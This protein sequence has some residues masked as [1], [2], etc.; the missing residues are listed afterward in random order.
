MNG[1]GDKSVTTQESAVCWKSKKSTRGK[2][3]ASVKFGSAVV[4]IYRLRSDGRTRFMLS[5][6]QEGKRERRSFSNL[7]AAKKEALLVAQRIQGR[8]QEMNDLRPHDGEAYRTL[9]ELL[10]PSGVP[11]VTAVQEYVRAN[12]PQRT[13]PRTAF[14]I[15]QIRTGRI[16][17]RPPRAEGRTPL[18]RRHRQ[19]PPRRRPARHRRLRIHRCAGTVRRPRQNPPPQGPRRP[20]PPPRRQGAPRQAKKHDIPP[21]DLVVVNL[22]PFEETVAKPDVTL[23]EAIENI[24]IGGPS[25][26]RSAAKNHSHVTVVVDPADYPRVIAEMKSTT[27]TPPRACASSSP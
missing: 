6:Y 25:M 16:R 1:C 8:R 7:D 10:R 18:H 9:V 21:I 20:A 24:D 26:L 12:K 23:E 2:P 11:L 19:G 22:Y 27:A 4:P 17:P 3:V 14:R 5:F 13:P 15:R